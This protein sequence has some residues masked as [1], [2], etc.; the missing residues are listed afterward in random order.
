MSSPKLLLDSVQQI[1]YGA[2]SKN[3][4]MYQKARAAFSRGSEMD[5]T[6]C[7]SLVT[8][9]RTY[10]FSVDNDKDFIDIFFGLQAT[11]SFMFDHSFHS[12]IQGICRLR[13]GKDEPEGS[14]AGRI[15]L[16]LYL[17][18]RCGMRAKR[19]AKREGI[20]L[21][22]VLLRAVA[23][24]KSQTATS[25]SSSAYNVNQIVEDWSNRSQTQLDSQHQHPLHLQT[26]RIQ[27]HAPQHYRID[28]H[29]Q[30]A[31]SLN[32]AGDYQ[33]ASG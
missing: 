30:A 16:G 3:L 27:H 31:N 18:Q 29:M 17:W 24:T 12:L 6:R 15:S 25:E 1:M 28:L 23:T 19:K 11:S 5:I 13:P 8:T 32:G 20:E 2:K 7:F 22:V 9:K 33:I 26:D 4:R 14:R 21:K 10:D